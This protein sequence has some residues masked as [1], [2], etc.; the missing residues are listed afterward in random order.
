MWLGVHDLRAARA[1]LQLLW[2]LLMKV[3]RKASMIT[4]SWSVT[5][6]VRKK[7]WVAFGFN[8]RQLALGFTINRYQ[9]S[10]DLLFFWFSVEL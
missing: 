5:M 4:R 10:L 6:H 3:I 2:E 7:F 8:Q 1:C 9:I